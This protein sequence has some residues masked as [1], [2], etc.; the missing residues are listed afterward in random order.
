MAQAQAVKV[1]TAST[2]AASDLAADGGHAR[3]RRA[4]SVRATPR[5]MVALKNN[6]CQAAEVL[7]QAVKKW[8]IVSEAAG[9]RQVGQAGEGATPQW[10]L[11]AWTSRRPCSRE[12]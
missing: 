9:G 10:C 1:V 4:S 2:T 11:L 6:R 5:A 7:E 3:K 12:K 8:R